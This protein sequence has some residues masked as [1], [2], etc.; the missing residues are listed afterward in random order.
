VSAGLAWTGMIAFAAYRQRTGARCRGAL[1]VEEVPG[2]WWW[3]FLT[4]VYMPLELPRAA[5]FGVAGAGAGRSPTRA[6]RMWRC[7]RRE[8]PRPIGV[9]ASRSARDECDVTAA[10]PR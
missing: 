9:T 6:V 2:A 8:S 1:R 7:E 4:L 5:A 10:R 3:L